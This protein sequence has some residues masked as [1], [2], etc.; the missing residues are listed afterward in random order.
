M[1]L[2]LPELEESEGEMERREGVGKSAARAA[3]REE[4]G[5]WAMVR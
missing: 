2:G 5:A 1:S 3:G 4:S